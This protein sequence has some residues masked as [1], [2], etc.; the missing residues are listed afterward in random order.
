MQ[1]VT[2][3]SYKPEQT[4]TCIVMAKNDETVCIITCSSI[5]VESIFRV[6]ISG[7]ALIFSIIDGS[8]AVFQY[9]EYIVK[10][11]TICH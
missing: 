10:S 5:L 7:N 9:F 11:K 2:K 1:V 6:S 3:K 8:N 4:N